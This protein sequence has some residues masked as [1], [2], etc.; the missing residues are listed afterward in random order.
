MIPY[1]IFAALQGVAFSNSPVPPA[2]VLPPQS[3]PPAAI[4]AI[5]TLSG[6]RKR[7]PAQSYISLGGEDYPVAALG[8]R[9][10]GTVRFTLTVDPGGRVV[11]CTVVHSS[12]SSVLDQATCNIMRRRARYTPAMDSNGNPVAGTIT[13]AIVWK[14]PR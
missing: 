11:G 9:A 6:P 13:E 12:G 10:E 3:V 4:Q 5:G 8:A 14:Y 1:L 7:I 2:I